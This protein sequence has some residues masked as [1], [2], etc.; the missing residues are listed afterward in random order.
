MAFFLP[1]LRQHV[2]PQLGILVI[3]VSIP[4]HSHCLAVDRY[5]SYLHAPPSLLNRASCRC[6]RSRS[7]L[8]IARAVSPLVLSC[9]QELPRI[10]PILCRR[11]SMR[12]SSS[13]VPSR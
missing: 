4:S 10:H 2:T 8:V 12:A 3:S 1:N 6:P 9:L 5:L 7:H 11:Q 13:S